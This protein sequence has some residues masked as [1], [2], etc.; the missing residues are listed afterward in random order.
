MAFDQVSLSTNPT[1]KKKSISRQRRR[2]AVVVIFE[3]AF[4]TEQHGSRKTCSTPYWRTLR[5]ET[6][7][8]GASR[9]NIIGT[10]DE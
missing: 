1:Q 6:Q 8:S 2:T 5:T 7:Q 9:E 10:R 4:V 3:Y